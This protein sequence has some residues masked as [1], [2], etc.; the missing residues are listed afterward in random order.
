M[1]QHRHA[2]AE[3]M[4]TYHQEDRPYVFP[5]FHRLELS[6]PRDAGV[7]TSRWIWSTPKV[8]KEK[9]TTGSKTMLSTVHVMTD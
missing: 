4:G 6:W 2:N 9:S 7:A 1:R 3:S 5:H 8:A